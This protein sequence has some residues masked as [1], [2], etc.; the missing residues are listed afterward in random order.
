MLTLPLA[1]RRS[2]GTAR[3]RRVSPRQFPMAARAASRTASRW[4]GSAARREG[5]AAV[6]GG[7]RGEEEVDM[8]M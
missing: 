4:P 3:S 1:A 7:A 8:E 6:R 2:P 5:A